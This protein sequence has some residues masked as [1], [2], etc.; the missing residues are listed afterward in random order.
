MKNEYESIEAT[1]AVS[2][3]LRK[4]LLKKVCQYPLTG[5]DQRELMNKITLLG[6]HVRVQDGECHVFKE[7]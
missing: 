4:Y 3:E 6:Y 7:Y 2:G 5:E 1:D